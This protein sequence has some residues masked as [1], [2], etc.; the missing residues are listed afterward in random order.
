VRR[1]GGVWVLLGDTG[2]GGLPGR[3]RV[4]IVATVE[5]SVM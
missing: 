5:M 3:N 4:G 1:E 2:V